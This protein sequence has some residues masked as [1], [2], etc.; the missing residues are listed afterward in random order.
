M[1]GDDIRNDIQAAIDRLSLALEN[2]GESRWPEQRWL[3]SQCCEHPNDDNCYCIVYR[4]VYRDFDEAQDPPIQYIADGETEEG[5]TWIAMMDPH[6]G[7]AMVTLLTVEMKSTAGDEN[8][9][10]C[11]ADTCTTIAAHEL[12]K[13]I[14][15]G[16]QP[17]KP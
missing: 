3:T 10:D 9:S 5:A 11:T 17:Q 16:Q 8:H 4:G 2:M 7:K 14:L 1:N 13:L 15:T 6:V 12:A